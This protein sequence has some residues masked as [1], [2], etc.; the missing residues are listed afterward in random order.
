MDMVK[1][2]N[3]AT[4]HHSRARLLP[5]RRFYLYTQS[6]MNRVSPTY[7]LATIAGFVRRCQ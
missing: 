1:H 4:T 3:S 6:W 5:D 7:F 2:R